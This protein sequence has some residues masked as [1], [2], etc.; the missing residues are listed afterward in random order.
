MSSQLNFINIAQNHKS[1]CGLFNVYKK[2]PQGVCVR[3]NKTDIHGRTDKLK[4]SSRGRCRY[5]GITIVWLS[6]NTCLNLLRWSMRTSGS[7]HRLSLMRPCCS[8]LQWGQRQASSGASWNTHSTNQRRSPTTL[9]IKTGLTQDEVRVFPL[10]SLLQ[11]NH[12][13]FKPQCISSLSQT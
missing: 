2:F 13:Q 12:M 1:W 5:R 4:T 6:W 7:V 8:C 11:R 10:P 9:L 3:K